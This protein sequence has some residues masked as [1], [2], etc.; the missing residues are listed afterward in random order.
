[1]SKRLWFAFGVA[2]FVAAGLIVAVALGGGSTHP[3]GEIEVEAAT[4]PES[5]MRLDDSSH[6]HADFPGWLAIGTPPDEFDVA[7]WYEAAWGPQVEPWT[8]LS[9][10]L[11]GTGEWLHFER[12]SVLLRPDGK[13]LVQ[14]FETADHSCP[15]TDDIP[16]GGDLESTWSNTASTCPDTTIVVFGGIRYDPKRDALGSPFPAVADAPKGWDRI[17]YPNAGSIAFLPGDAS[18]ISVRLPGASDYQRYALS[19]CP[20]AP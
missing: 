11:R 19:V 15:R 18:E 6:C 9:N 8:G 7:G 12:L 3:M 16:W 13:F 14:T 17:D 4:P 5:S 2:L 20:P 10:S 1:M